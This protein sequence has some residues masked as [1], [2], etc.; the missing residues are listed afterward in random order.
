MEIYPSLISSDL[1]NLKQTM[2]LLDPH[3]Q[4]YHIDVMDNHFVP[5]LT[6]GPAFIKA[7]S[8]ATKL[9]LHVHLMVDDPQKWVDM[10]DLSKKDLFVFHV[11]AAGDDK[12]IAQLIK[13]VNAKNIPVG[14]AVNPQTP[15]ESIF[16]FLP[17]LAQVLLMSVEPGFSGQEYMSLVEEKIAPLVSRKQDGLSFKICMDG[18]I[19]VSNIKKLAGM[20]VEQFGIASAIFG[21]D[22]PV[23]AIQKLSQI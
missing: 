11:E 8:G 3:C 15:I 10:L 4:G 12:K 1:L 23:A 9:P 13:M 19:N 18:G 14:I 5:N 22:D 2:Q 16:D 21:G 17:S 7:M 20:G 6:W